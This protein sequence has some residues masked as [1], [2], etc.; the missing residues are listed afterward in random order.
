MI[1][2]QHLGG[3]HRLMSVSSRQAWST[4]QVLGQSPKTSE[5]PHFKKQIKNDTHL[6]SCL[7]FPRNWKR[8]ARDFRVKMLAIS[9][10]T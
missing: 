4:G 5:K 6:T 1:L 2:I 3:R 9:L 8:Q 7:P 10:T